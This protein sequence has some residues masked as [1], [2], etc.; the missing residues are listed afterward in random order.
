VSLV[1]QRYYKKI[2]TIDGHQIKNKRLETLEFV[3]FAR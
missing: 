3:G 1:E 2:K